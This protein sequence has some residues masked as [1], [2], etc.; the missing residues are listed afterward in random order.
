MIN[1]KLFSLT[2]MLII[3]TIFSSCQI[4][5]STE[6]SKGSYDYTDGLAFSLT[7]NE[8]AFVVSGYSGNE[9]SIIIPDRYKND[10]GQDAPVVG[11][12][13]FAFYQNEVITNIKFPKSLKYIEDSAFF[14]AINLDNIVLPTSLVDIGGQAFFETKWLKDK[15]AKDSVL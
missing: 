8:E 9:A 11:V 2:S 14:A 1:K 15:Q 6:I 12:S 5:A 4:N 10:K 7:N 13:S 3:S